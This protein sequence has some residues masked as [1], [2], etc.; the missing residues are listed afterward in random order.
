MGVDTHSVRGDSWG[1]DQR[2][3]NPIPGLVVPR[4]WDDDG[5][6]HEGRRSFFNVRRWSPVRP[7]QRCDFPNSD[8]L[9]TDGYDV[10]GCGNRESMPCLLF[11]QTIS[12]CMYRERR[13]D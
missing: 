2:K 12:E 5:R 9:N 1:V 3:L 11:N 8:F 10:V 4:I 7:V 6:G 13:Q